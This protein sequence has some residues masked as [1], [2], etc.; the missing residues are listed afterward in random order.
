MPH[1]LQ[2]L[3]RLMTWR[4]FHFYVE[5]YRSI[6]HTPAEYYFP[7]NVSMKFERRCVARE[8]TLATLIRRARRRL[9]GNELLSQGA[10]ASSAALAAFI[11][12]LLLGTE[13]LRWQ[14]ALLI[15][16]VAAAVGL[17]RVRQRMPSSYSV[18]QIVDHRMAL[19]D[20][21]STA[22]FFSEVAPDADVS[23]EIRRS[24]FE[25]AGQIA[26]SVDVRKAIPYTMPRSLYLLGAL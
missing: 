14:W 8:M 12:L 7:E 1:P 26:E 9:L 21:I 15:P 13:I 6:A 23:P 2:A 10:N 22:V 11:L 20:S 4:P 16:L 25:I 17:Y 18:A 5:H 24:Q 3:P 19:A